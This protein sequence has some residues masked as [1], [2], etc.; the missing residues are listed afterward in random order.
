MAQIHTAIFCSLA[1][2]G[3]SILHTH[4]EEQLRA[5][6]I[7]DSLR[8]HEAYYAAYTAAG[9]QLRTHFGENGTIIKHLDSAPD[10][11]VIIAAIIQDMKDAY[12]ISDSNAAYLYNSCDAVR[13]AFS[14]TPDDLTRTLAEYTSN[15][16]D[17]TQYAER[18]DDN[19]VDGWQAAVIRNEIHQNIS[20][21]YNT[22]THNIKHH[23]QQQ[24]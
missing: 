19:H 21:A 4:T 16:A 10:D 22:I 17:Y 14:Q 13:R 7:L 2:I 1:L 5:C 18:C 23:V 12:G 8:H 15:P 6:I 24:R 3:S 11:S 9:K 20:H